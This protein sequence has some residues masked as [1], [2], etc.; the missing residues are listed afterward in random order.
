[1]P[2]TVQESIE[3]RCPRCTRLL[4][5]RRGEL[6]NAKI[7]I[8]CTCRDIVTVG[9]ASKKLPLARPSKLT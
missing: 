4:F 9:G 3:E 6:G 7:E 5:K 1:M 2:E 8:K